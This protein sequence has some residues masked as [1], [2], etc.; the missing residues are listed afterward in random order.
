MNQLLIPRK[1]RNKAYV[2]EQGKGHRTKVSYY[3]P[4]GPNNLKRNGRELTVE[5]AGFKMTLKGTEINAI[6]SLLRKVGEIVEA[7]E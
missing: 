6:K 3:R 2:M 4:V 5:K 1:Y 7:Y